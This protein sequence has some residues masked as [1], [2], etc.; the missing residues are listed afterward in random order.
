MITRI[1]EAKSLSSSS[2]FIIIIVLVVVSVAAIVVGGGDGFSRK[3]A[4]IDFREFSGKMLLAQTGVVGKILEFQQSGDGFT[5]NLQPIELDGSILETG[6]K[7]ATTVVP[8]REGDTPFSYRPEEGLRVTQGY[9]LL[10]EYVEENNLGADGAVEGDDLPDIPGMVDCSSDALPGGFSVFFEDVAYNT[11]IGFDDP[12]YG[13]PRQSAICSVMS[14]FEDLL[15]LDDTGLRPGVVIQSSV[16]GTPEH[17]LSVVSPQY[18]GGSGFVSTLLADYLRT[19]QRRSSTSFSDNV[20]VLGVNSGF[21]RFNFIN[22]EIAWSVDTGQDT[23]YDMKTVTRQNMLRLLGFGSFLGH[24]QENILSSSWKRWTEWDR[25]LFDN[26]GVSLVD[27]GTL[28]F[29]SVEYQPDEFEPG[30][31]TQYDERLV[32]DNQND[33][34]SLQGL[35]T[36][37]VFEISASQT[38]NY[39]LFTPSNFQKGVSLSGLAD[40]SAVSY[41]IIGAGEE[42]QVSQAEREIL[43][44]LGLQVDGVEGCEQAPRTV[45]SDIYIERQNNKAVCVTIQDGLS[46]AATDKFMVSGEISELSGTVDLSNPAVFQLYTEPCESDDFESTDEREAFYEIYGTTDFQEAKSFSWKPSESEDVYREYVQFQYQAHDTFSSRPSDVRTIGIH[47]CVVTPNSNQLCNGDFQFSG[48]TSPVDYKLSSLI[49]D[50]DNDGNGII[51]CESTTMPGWCAQ[52]VQDGFSSEFGYTWH[53]YLIDNP[54]AFDADIV[55]SPRRYAGGSTGA[56]IQRLR[57]P[58]QQNVPYI[59]SGRVYVTEDGL[60]PTFWYGSEEAVLRQPDGTFHI[61]YPEG[62]VGAGFPVATEYILTEPLQSGEWHTFAWTLNPGNQTVTHIA[63]G[64]SNNNGFIL[65]DDLSIQNASE[66]GDCFTDM[67]GDCVTNTGDLLVLLGQFEG[68]CPNDSVGCPGDITFDGEVTTADILIFLGQYGSICSIDE[69]LPDEITGGSSGGDSFAGGGIGGDDYDCPPGRDCY[70]ND[71]EEFII[72]DDSAYFCIRDGSCDDDTI[73]QLQETAEDLGGS[74][75]II[76][77]G[78]GEYQGGLVV[79]SEL[80]E[81]EFVVPNSNGFSANFAMAVSNTTRRTIEEISVIGALPSMVLYDSHVAT[82]ENVAYDSGSN[83]LFIPELDGGETV[84]IYFKI[85][86]NSNVCAQAEREAGAS[87]YNL[88][89]ELDLCD[90]YQEVISKVYTP[91]PSTT[92]N[93]SSGTRSIIRGGSGGGASPTKPQCSDGI[94]ND[95]DRLFDYPR[96]TDCSSASDTLEGSEGSRPQCSDGVDND[97]NGKTDYPADPG[98]TSSG[99][100]TEGGATSQCSDGIDNDGDTRIDFPGDTGCNSAADNT[101]DVNDRQCSDGV[102]NDADGAIDFPADAQC[103]STSDSSESL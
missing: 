82:Q 8:P 10:R 24:E 92:T 1:K 7:Y 79:K 42:K 15:L 22:D 2:A 77:I 83:T 74:Q 25:L 59:V 6:Q 66:C 23:D 86:L 18:V 52:G 31:P 4:G 75:Q 36:P 5:L 17:A 65:Y 94:D 21:M 68:S 69:F 9:P 62:L 28:N 60:Q 81:N 85:D 33:F 76:V 54:E 12:T 34:V 99:D 16:E 37:D 84:Y 30:D 49:N 98:C 29:I 96:D 91:N 44:M 97:S 61:D 45:A 19:G 88:L 102:D 50:T 100:T 46:N 103:S 89:V 63:F 3:F 67:S 47:K 95:G 27:P 90:S 72:V 51:G 40:P 20:S 11:G 57:I 64:G 53:P 80:S 14:E 78:E 58:L 43:C 48:A 70:S 13:E 56:L 87:A 41:P 38:A 39:N 32:G 35:Q 101:E 26:E 93:T 73:R 55:T 71:E